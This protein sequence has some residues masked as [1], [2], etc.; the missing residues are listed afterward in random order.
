MV[1]SQY[2]P[3]ASACSAIYFTLESLPQLHFLYQVRFNLSEDGE[4]KKSKLDYARG[5]TSKCVTS[6]GEHVRGLA[7]GQQSS[8]ET[9]Q[10]WR[11]IGE[12]ANLSSPGIK[13]QTFRTDSLCLATG[14]TGP[15]L[16]KMQSKRLIFVVL[17]S[18]L[19]ERLP[20]RLV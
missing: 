17:S 5:I 1:S 16:W 7:P 8:K 18:F 13:S 15:F 12:T 3:L 19:L 6:D 2:V 4:C 9:S 20:H 10:R 11:A 14:L